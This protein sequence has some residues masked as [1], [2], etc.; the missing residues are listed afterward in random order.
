MASPRKYVCTLSVSSNIQHRLLFVNSMVRFVHYFSFFVM[1][2]SVTGIIK[3]AATKRPCYILV[4]HEQRKCKSRPKYTS[5]FA[6][7]IYLN[8]FR[9][10]IS[11]IFIIESL[12][13][14]VIF[15][16][17]K[18]NKFKSTYIH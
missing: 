8:R 13:I 3:T 7:E 5:H 10:S 17:R 2:V 14:H 12:F 18:I 11:Q 6:V 4:F 9:P 16:F 15:N 1:R